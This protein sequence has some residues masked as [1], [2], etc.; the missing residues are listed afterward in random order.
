M[1]KAINQPVTTDLVIYGGVYI[2]LYEVAE[3]GTIIPQH[4]HKFSHCTAILRGAV[5]AWCDDGPARDYMAPAV[6]KIPAG[7]RHMFVT[8]ENAVSMACIH[9]ADRLEHDEPVVTAEHTL[10]LEH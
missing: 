6:I 1:K 5:R 4:S 3:V 9:N 7:T 10:D 2:K 8:L